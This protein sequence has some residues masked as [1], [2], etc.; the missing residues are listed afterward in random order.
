[1]KIS[2]LIKNLQ[3]V[4]NKDGDLEC[5]YASDD[6]GNH[7]CPIYFDAGTFYTLK[8]NVENNERDIEV[9]N[10]NDLQDLYDYEECKPEDIV[11]IC[12]VN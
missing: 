8:E 2:K 11:K 12:I 9:Y 6:E 7:H 5:Y 10:E 3:D 1:M 4:L